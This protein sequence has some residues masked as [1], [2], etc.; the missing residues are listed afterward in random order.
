MSVTVGS[1]A[2]EYD[3]VEVNKVSWDGRAEAVGCL[4]RQWMLV[5]D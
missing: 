5:G 1:E 4:L 3:R 2:D